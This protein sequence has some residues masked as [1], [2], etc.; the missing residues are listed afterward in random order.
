M[1]LNEYIS[2]RSLI[3][4]SLNGDREVIPLN[5]PSESQPG[6]RVYVEGY[7]HSE[8]GGKARKLK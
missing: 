8:L 1:S 5:P 7:S 4:F 2:D 3:L 6:D